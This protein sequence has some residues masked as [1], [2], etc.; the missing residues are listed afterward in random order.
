MCLKAFETKNPDTFQSKC[1]IAGG[2]EILSVAYWL[3]NDCLC[4]CDYAEQESS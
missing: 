1:H 3:K 4:G 2:A